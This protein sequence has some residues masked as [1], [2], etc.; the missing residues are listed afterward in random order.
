MKKLV[1]SPRVF[2]R[3]NKRVI[4]TQLSLVFRLQKAIELF[5]DKIE[6]KRE[7][8]KKDQYREYKKRRALLPSVCMCV[9]WFF[10]SFFKENEEEKCVGFED[11][12]TQ[13]KHGY[14]SFKQKS[15]MRFS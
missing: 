1:F 15:S 5:F 7:K 6:R 9:F 13:T 11:I 10:F 14:V 8:K 2:N 12:N 3:K 4:E